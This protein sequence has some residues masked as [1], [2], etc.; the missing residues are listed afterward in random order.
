MQLACKKACFACSCTFECVSVLQVVPRQ[1]CCARWCRHDLS[2]MVQVE[3]DGRFMNFVDQ[4]LW[5]NPDPLDERF[6]QRVIA[7]AGASQAQKMPAVVQSY[8]EQ[9]CTALCDGC[10]T[11]LTAM[12]SSG[13]AEFMTAIGRHCGLSDAP[14]T[15]SVNARQADC[16][17]GGWPLQMDCRS[18]PA[19]SMQ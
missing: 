17:W 6:Q 3:R 4:Q 9:V 12:E 15:P 8:S 19:I 7:L 14:L 16:C 11:S 2:P 18:R 1:L 5:Q 10:Q 13:P